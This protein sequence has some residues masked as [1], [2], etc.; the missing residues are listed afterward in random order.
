MPVGDECS[1]IFRNGLLCS[2]PGMPLSSTNWNTLRSRGSSSPSS[3]LQMKTIVSAYGPF[4]M[5]VFDPF[6]RYSSPSR[7]AVDSIDPNASDPD[8]G[9]VIAHAPIVSSVSRSGTQRSR[10]AIVP[11]L[12]MAAAVRPTLTPSAVTMPGEHLHSSMIGIMAIAAPKPDRPLPSPS[13]SSVA[14][15]FGCGFRSAAMRRSNDSRPIAPIP[16]TAYNL[17]SSS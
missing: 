3:S 14:A 12:S 15:S 2:S 8:P 5:N 6:K 7:R 4:V 17:R 1:P 13:S 9:S 11:R 16:N 10:W